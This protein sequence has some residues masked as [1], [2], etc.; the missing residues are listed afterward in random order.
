MSKA[1]IF[2]II[3][4]FNLSISFAQ[5]STESK[6]DF[7]KV[8]S[9]LQNYV[10][11]NPRE[12]IHI[13]FDKRSYV[14]GDTVWFKIY[15]VNEQ[16]NKLSTISKLVHLAIQAPNEQISRMLVP[17]TL[18][19]GYSQLV[20]KDSLSQKG[21]YQLTAYTNWMRN[22]GSEYF[23]RSTLFVSSN[24]TITP[25]QITENGTFSSIKSQ[26]ISIKFFP[27]GGSLNNGIRT[28]IAFKAVNGYGV[29]TLVNGFIKDEK[30][31]TAAYI[32]SEHAGIGLFAL[33]P[34]L[35][36]TYT[37]VIGATNNRQEIPFPLSIERG[38]QLS[39]NWIEEN[40]LSI[41]IRKTSSAE[42]YSEVRLLIHANGVVKQALV[43]P[44]KETSINLNIS[45]DKLANGINT[46]CLFSS[47]NI[48]LAERSVFSQHRKQIKSLLESDKEVYNTRDKVKLKIVVSD[49]VGK[50]LVG[51]YS[52]A[53]VKVEKELESVENQ[54]NIYTDLLLNSN[55]NGFVEDPNYYFIEPEQKIKE[56]DALM[57]TQ[58]SPSFNWA[59]LISGTSISPK[60]KPELDLNIS[61]WVT[62]L[63]GKA[64]PNAKI[65]L[66]SIKEMVF[67][68][69]VSDVEGK[70]RFDSLNF[71]ETA[72]LILRATS[73]KFG[74]NI[75]IMLDVPDTVALTS[76]R[77]IRP[78]VFNDASVRQVSATETADQPSKIRQGT[79]LKTVEIKTRRNRDIKGSVY[80]FAAPPPDY[81]LE[82][83]KLQVMGSLQSYLG[84]R[85]AGVQVRGDK[86]Y[87][88]RGQMVIL[89]NGF[90]I[91]DL[92]GISPRALTGVQIIKSGIVAQNMAT[93]LMLEGSGGGIVF[94]TQSGAT[95]ITQTAGTLKHTI[96]GY[97]YPSDFN[98]V[99]YENQKDALDKD[100]RKTSGSNLIKSAVVAKEKIVKVNQRIDTTKIAT[101]KT[102][103]IKTRRN[104]DIKGSVYPFATAPP[105]YTIEFEKLQQL[106][107]LMPS[108][109]GLNGV[110]VNG[111]NLKGRFI[112]EGKV[113]IGPMVILLDGSPIEDL[114]AISPKALAGVQI[115][116]SGL[117]AQGMANALMLG[118]GPNMYG[119]EAK[120]GIVFLTLNR[121]V[122]VSQSSGT[123]KHAIKGYDYPLD[124]NLANNKD[125]SKKDLR[126]TLFWKPN[127]VTNQDGTA[128]AIFYTSDLTG[129]FRITLQGITANGNITQ[130]V[131]YIEVK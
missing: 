99:D 29:G 117:V 130:I 108:L 129:T 43:L 78:S 47:E 72:D 37:A 82:E 44:M 109:F 128:E 38:L 33:T 103:E 12:K 104:R 61:G 59:E 112:S 86:V 125:M 77:E 49:S 126:S 20:L 5:Q 66:A 97:D 45:N 93:A 111:D 11:N 34:K 107:V 64:M 101:L 127:I 80:P 69:A 24:S 63:A 131:K 91:D 96:K 7:T 122:S 14:V 4:F 88:T 56:L 90:V 106:N 83:D 120:F 48:L 16:G 71:G 6:S 32:K 18:G 26:N 75:K 110:I 51:G 105:D 95:P 98:S 67:L 3:L 55:L 8:I 27:E 123:L 114:L 36:S 13:H 42:A 35:G 124:F 2:S 115:V 94:L 60:Y 9:S 76:D 57:I 19:M 50:G 30:G 100:S 84:G 81:T 89:L 15:L 92:S 23:F 40:N 62:D 10:E 119:Q 25:T 70:F 102:V 41:S 113:I 79:T 17:I 116:R 53:V 31:D 73:A 68:N 58:Q 65:S 85:F 118:E 87:G 28:K 1:F 74:K 52:I 39:A 121:G 46:I 54:P 22:A 21:K